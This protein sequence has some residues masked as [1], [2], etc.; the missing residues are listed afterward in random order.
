MSKG[1]KYSRKKFGP[2]TR[3]GAN[4]KEASVVKTKEKWNLKK[5]NSN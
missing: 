5:N 1:R 3:G 2:I 4:P